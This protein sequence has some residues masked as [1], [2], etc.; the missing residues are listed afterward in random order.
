MTLSELRFIVAVARE[1]HFGR[2]AEFC[3]VSQPTL[4]VAVKK[5]EREL[6][7]I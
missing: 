6:D 5:L 4:S 2:A 3:C 1:R 7:I